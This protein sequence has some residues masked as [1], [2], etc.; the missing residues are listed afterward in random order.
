MLV[1]G[2]P[3][4]GISHLLAGMSPAVRAVGLETDLA[5]PYPALT[6]ALRQRLPD[7][8]GEAVEIV[9][10]A[11]GGGL[12]AVDDAEHLDEPSI[13]L[14]VGLA[15]RLPLAVG[16][17]PGR[18]RA[19]EVLGRFG[20]WPRVRP[21]RLGDAALRELVSDWRGG[22]DADVDPDAIVARAAG[23]PGVARAL[24][25]GGW[26]EASMTARYGALLDALEPEDRCWLLACTLAPD[27]FDL[28]R[29]GEPPPALIEL[30]VAPFDGATC[31]L[32]GELLVARSD[33]SQ[34][35]GARRRLAD[36]AD[37]AAHR[38]SLLLAAGDRAAAVAAARAA[39]ADES[40]QADRRATLAALAADE[41]TT[42]LE[43]ARVLLQ[44][45]RPR[46][47][48]ELL[49]ALSESAKGDPAATL[50]RAIALRQRDDARRWPLLDHLDPTDA[51]HRTELDRQRCWA[52]G[53]IDS[54]RMHATA[55]VPDPAAAED[56]DRA[57][58]LWH[59]AL[60]ARAVDGSEDW[61]S[62][63][64]EG[65]AA[66]DD[67]PAAW[68][69][70]GRHARALQRWHL[71]G[72]S[73]ELDG[74]LDRVAEP[75]LPAVVVDAHRAVALADTGTTAEALGLAPEPAGEAVERA[76]AAWARAEAEWAAGHPVAARRAAE[77]VAALDTPPAWLAQVCAAWAA[78]ETGE[79]VVPLTSESTTS[80]AA[81]VRDEIIAIATIDDDP[82]TAAAAFASLAGR[83]ATVHRRGELRCRWATGEATRLAGDTES[84][85]TTLLAVEQDCQTGPLLQ[86]VRRSLRLAG[87]RRTGRRSSASGPLSPREAEVIELV[88]KGLSTRDIAVRLGLSATTVETQITSA[89]NKLGARSRLQ[90]ALAYREM[91]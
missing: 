32:V 89:M 22:G 80:L 75:A 54:I 36:R 2:A 71:E 44:R 57:R 60:L 23:L 29:I 21:P 34:L 47:A 70:L 39:L 26:F 8:H 30:G 46:E 51:H 52:D 90:A 83:W 64:L 20:G 42:R 19:R 7:D 63:Q 74:A 69:Q 78:W 55:S 16:L 27:G 66:R 9:V 56:L 72:A 79:T 87:V 49:D 28:D 10:A 53:R 11:A 82:A 35:A 65:L 50:L 73:V 15:D 68:R 58:W 5:I 88:G 48:I 45:E 31:G 62:E 91:Q 86:R 67:V 84:A 59:A 76:L 61:L 14:L 81:L 40:L 38:S 25:L 4:S 17:H 77:A 13:E 6:A 18:G 37:D 43:A 24:T 85:V 12:L 3:G 1:I 33:E 41:D